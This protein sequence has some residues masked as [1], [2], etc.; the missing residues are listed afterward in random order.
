MLEQIY[1]YSEGAD[2]DGDSDDDEDGSQPADITADIVKMELGSTLLEV[3]KG[4]ERELFNLP[5]SGRFN[6]DNCLAAVSLATVAGLE[7]GDIAHRLRCA[8]QVPGRLEVVAKEPFLVI[9]DF[10]HTSAALHNIISTVRR[11]T[12]GRLIVVFG[13][14]GDRDL[15]LI[16]I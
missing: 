16:H 13:A 5:L 4:S 7:L 2:E 11:F 15:S 8:P 14:G 10:A 9:I 6:V 1:E 3:T 12:D